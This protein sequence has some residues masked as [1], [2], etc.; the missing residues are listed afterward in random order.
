M[1]GSTRCLDEGSGKGTRM[2][3]RVRRYAREV[4]YLWRM[5]RNGR[6][7]LVCDIS[8]WGAYWVCLER[9]DE[10]FADE[11]NEWMCVY[12]GWKFF[13]TEMVGIWV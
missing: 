10:R 6:I 8:F 13:A 1:L 7:S 11:T 5:C 9:S 2:E 4:G 12:G 3:L